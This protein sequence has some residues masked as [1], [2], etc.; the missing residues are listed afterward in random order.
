VLKKLGNEVSVIEDFS[1]N[2]TSGRFITEESDGLATDV[3]L[4]LSMRSAPFNDMDFNGDWFL[5]PAS[6]NNLYEIKNISPDVLPKVK[7][8]VELSLKKI[9]Y[10]YTPIFNVS[11]G[12]V[13]NRSVRVVINVFDN[14]SGS[15]EHEFF[16]EVQ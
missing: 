7:N 5:H 2:S 3:V 6:G 13:I 8:L 14:N 12:P 9:I 15:F 11:I 4:L 1:F 16:V 10:D